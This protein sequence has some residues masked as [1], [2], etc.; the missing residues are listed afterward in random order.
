MAGVVDV[1]HV[2]DA[3]P[4]T[5]TDTPLDEQ[6]KTDQSHTRSAPM[7]T[8]PLTGSARGVLRDHATTAISKLFA[9]VNFLDVVAHDALEVG[10]YRA[11]AA[12]GSA[13]ADH[14]RRVFEA[15]YGK[16]LNVGVTIK[17]QE[18]LPDWNALPVDQQAVIAAELDR[19]A[20][21]LLRGEAP[22]W[23]LPEATRVE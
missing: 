10:D 15:A 3:H 7:P 5:V 12:A 18:D 19:R 20:E 2:S 17:S 1:S 22:A 4:P 16:Q 13:W 14:A 6:P 8:G 21:R 23:A 11:A 9:A